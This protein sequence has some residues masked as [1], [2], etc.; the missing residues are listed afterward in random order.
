MCGNRRERPDNTWNTVISTINSKYEVLRT[1]YYAR[2][3]L[4][5]ALTSQNLLN[6]YTKYLLIIDT[7]KKLS[8]VLEC[9]VLVLAVFARGCLWW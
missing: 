9:T 6:I 1:W 2:F 4:H 5:F 7:S 3:V 8:S